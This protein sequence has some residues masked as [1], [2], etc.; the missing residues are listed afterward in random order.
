[1]TKRGSLLFAVVL[2][3]VSMSAGVASAQ[4]S[5]A[6]LPTFT[7]CT[8]YPLGAMVVFNNHKYT[9]TGAAIPNNRDCPPA[10]P[11]DPSN[12]NWW[13][14]NGVC[15]GAATATS[16]AT[17]TTRPRATATA[18]ARPTATSRATATATSRTRATATA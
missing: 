14:D 8:A 6:G 16:T 5:C 2:L 10:H 17:A 4:V 15:S 1:M 7:I 3:G 18:T 11:F 9:V 12:D 13:T